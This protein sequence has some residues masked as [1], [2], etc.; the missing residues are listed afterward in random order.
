MAGQIRVS[1]AEL[2]VRAKRYGQGS[3]QITSVLTQLQ[4]LQDQL[5]TEWEGR[6]FEGFQQQWDQ[7]RPKVQNFAELLMAIQHQLEQTAGAMREHDE[8]LSRNFGFK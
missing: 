7:L 1:P 6:A 8:A 5:A 3:E 4:S 2:E